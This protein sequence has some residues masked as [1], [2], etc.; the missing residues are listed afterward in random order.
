MRP[1]QLEVTNC[2]LKIKQKRKT[3]ATGCRNPEYS[4]KVGEKVGESREKRLVEGLVER[5]VE[6]QRK[7]I[8][9]IKQNAHVSKKELSDRIGISTT[10]I[11]KNIA[12]LKKKG[13]LRRIGPDKGGHWEIIKK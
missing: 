5:L 11:D 12:Q 9:F 2:G 10:A 1:V 8:N 3:A 7:I 6:S 4:L 13:I